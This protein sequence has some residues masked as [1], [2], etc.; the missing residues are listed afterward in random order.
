[1]KKK[2]RTLSKLD[3]PSTNRLSGEA[4]HAVASRL[5][6]NRISKGIVSPVCHR[7]NPR[8]PRNATNTNANQPCCAQCILARFL[9]ESV[10]ALVHISGHL[11]SDLVC[12]DHD[13]A[14]RRNLHTSGGP[15]LEETGCSFI[16]E[17]VPYESRHGHL[18]WHDLR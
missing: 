1:M 18:L 9:P 10:L 14:C 6:D 17:N 7:F 13:C 11:L 15:S 5:P 3:A 16:F 4:F 12:A 2:L 8:T